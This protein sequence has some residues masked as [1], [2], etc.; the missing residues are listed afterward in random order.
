MGQLEE[1]VAAYCSQFFAYV[2]RESLYI[3]MTLDT[4][5]GTDTFL[6]FPCG[7]IAGIVRPYKW[8]F[9]IWEELCC[10]VEH[11]TYANFVGEP[12]DDDIN[13]GEFN[14][15]HKAMPYLQLQQ[16][17]PLEKEIQQI[18]PL[19]D[20]IK[21]RLCAAEEKDYHVFM[22]FVAHV[23]KYPNRT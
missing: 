18:Q 3:M 17:A 10:K 15:C 9:T 22:Q 13:P 6:A 21:S 23:A 11:A 5:G 4:E 7:K 14:L 16:E 12:F 19:L 8:G 2:V 1:T 20:H